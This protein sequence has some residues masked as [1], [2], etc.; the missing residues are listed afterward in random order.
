[1]QVR[2]ATPPAGS[3]GRRAGPACL[4]LGPR[5]SQRLCRDPPPTRPCTPHLRPPAAVRRGRWRLWASAWLQSASPVGGWGAAEA[6]RPAL[7]TL[8]SSSTRRAPPPLTQPYKPTPETA[9]ATH[10]LNDPR[11]QAQ[12]L[13]RPAPG[14]QGRPAGVAAWGRAAGRQGAAQ[15]AQW[16][17]PAAAI[18]A[19]ACAGS[20]C[21]ARSHVPAARDDQSV[22]GVWLDVIKRGIQVEQVPRLLA[23]RLVA[24]RG[25]SRGG[26]G[27]FWAGREVGAAARRRRWPRDGERA[28]EPA[29]AFDSGVSSG[30]RPAAAPVSPPPHP[31]HLKVVHRSAA[32]V[33]RL[34][35]R[36]HGIHLRHTEGATGH[37]RCSR[38]RQCR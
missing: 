12:V 35:A 18:R 26:G 21:L 1:M 19:G 31:P 22:V 16:A 20:V 32:R 4:R 14:A 2:P 24:L 37:R 7:G 34:L 15:P 30:S 27:V 3:G 29:A 17:P 23:V 10:Q 9:T 8:S 36:A 5:L 13:R 25:H 11:V 6:Q 33:A 38:G 28:L